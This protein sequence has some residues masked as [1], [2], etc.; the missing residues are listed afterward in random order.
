MSFLQFICVYSV[1]LS[2]PC[3]NQWTYT[4]FV[5]AGT[6]KLAST[7]DMGML[8]GLDVDISDVERMQIAKKII[9]LILLDHEKIENMI[10]EFRMQLMLG[11]FDYF[12]CSEHI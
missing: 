12:L 1:S 5:K 2:H 8:P 6:G 3:H 7:N 4:R 9:S 11:I 10:L